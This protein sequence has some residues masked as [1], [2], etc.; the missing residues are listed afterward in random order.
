MVD[1]LR[2]VVLES[3]SLL[4]FPGELALLGAWIVVTTGVAL[5]VFKFT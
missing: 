2:G 3:Q 5:R 1:S 4:E